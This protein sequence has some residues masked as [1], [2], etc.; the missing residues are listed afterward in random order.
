[1]ATPEM[2][3]PERRKKTVL[4]LAGGA[5]SLL[6]PLAGAI[7]LH[8]SQNAGA[9]G[10]TGRSDVFER[11]DGEDRKIVPTQS[12]AVTSASGLTAPPPSGMI[13][14]SVEKPAGSSLDFIKSNSEMQAKIAESKAAVPAVSSAPAAAA[15]PEPVA[16]PPKKASGKPGKR[17]FTMPKLQ[18][19]RGFSSFGSSGKNGAKVGAPAG[20]AGGQNPQDMLKNL[21][22][23]AEKDP[24]VREY[25]KNHQ[26]Q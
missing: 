19:T 4:L 2:E 11:R 10:P 15:A 14:G 25:L 23:G 3:P 20:N 6:I 13:A 26:G 5:A 17:E 22:P 24:R 9:S 12:A 7:Y 1:M 16:A 8:W 21:P 18:V